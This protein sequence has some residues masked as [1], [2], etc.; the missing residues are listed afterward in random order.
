MNLI[1]ALVIVVQAGIVE[2]YAAQ[3][4]TEYGESRWAFKKPRIPLRCIRATEYQGL[5]EP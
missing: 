3:R 4:T 2:S 1:H 5:G